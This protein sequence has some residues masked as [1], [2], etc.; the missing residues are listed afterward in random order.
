MRLV[1]EVSYILG[2]QTKVVV[3]CFKTDSCS[4]NI[5]ISVSLFTTVLSSVP[6]K[7]VKGLK[8]RNIAHFNR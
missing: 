7:R 6:N 2:H 8:V 4:R 1:L 5:R 3:F